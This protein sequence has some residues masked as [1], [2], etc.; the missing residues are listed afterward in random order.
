MNKNIALILLYTLECVAMLSFALLIIVCYSGALF[1]IPIN[2][3][4]KMERVTIRLFHWTYNGVTTSY[5]DTPG[6]SI[7]HANPN[8]GFVVYQNLFSVNILL[9]YI[10]TISFYFLIFG[11]LLIAYHR[12]C[13]QKKSYRKWSLDLDAFKSIDIS[14]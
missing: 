7:F 13:S 2:V 5:E 10:W 12:K 6:K 8:P 1:N 11:G 9:I 14:F 3:S 4:G